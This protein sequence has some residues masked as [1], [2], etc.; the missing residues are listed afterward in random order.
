MPILAFADE[1]GSSRIAKRLDSTGKVE[2]TGVPVAVALGDGVTAGLTA[3]RDIAKIIGL[4][5]MTSPMK[6][7]HATKRMKRRSLRAIELF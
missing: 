1:S 4:V 6:I 2:G 5:P 3:E 7:M